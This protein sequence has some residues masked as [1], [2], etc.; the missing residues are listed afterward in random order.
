MPGKSNVCPAKGKQRIKD[1]SVCVDGTNGT[2]E[3][4]KGC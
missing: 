1:S 4:V 3:R 2:G